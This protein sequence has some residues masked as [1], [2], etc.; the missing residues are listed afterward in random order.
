MVDSLAAAGQVTTLLGG[1]EGAGGGPPSAEETEQL[2]IK[3]ICFRNVNA[4]CGIDRQ[5]W[6]PL[7]ALLTP[8]MWDLLET[9]PPLLL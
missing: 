2:K 3:V 9:P 8:E 7:A 5:Q 4:R 1:E 6:L